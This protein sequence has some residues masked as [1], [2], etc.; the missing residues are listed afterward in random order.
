MEDKITGQLAKPLWLN[1]LVFDVLTCSLKRHARIYHWA[2]GMRQ[3]ADHECPVCPVPF[4]LNE[5]LGLLKTVHPSTQ[6]QGIYPKP[7]T[8]DLL[9]SAHAHRDTACHAAQVKGSEVI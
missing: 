7:N 2:E 3:F 4:V 9:R 6:I 8:F 5:A 1:L